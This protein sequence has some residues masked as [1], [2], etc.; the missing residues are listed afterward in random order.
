MPFQIECT[1][2]EA[3]DFAS[4]I[5]QFACSTRG[6]DPAGFNTTPI[7][8]VLLGH[9]DQDEDETQEATQPLIRAST[10]VVASLKREEVKYHFKCACGYDTNYEFSLKAHLRTKRAALLK[11]ADISEAGA[12]KSPV[13]GVATDDWTG[14]DLHIRNFHQWTWRLEEDSAGESEDVVGW[15]YTERECF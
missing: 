5:S 8:K 6:V 4:A 9:R 13:C 10:D 1:K 12:Y 15:W 11:C 14:L 2:S 3:E 7:V